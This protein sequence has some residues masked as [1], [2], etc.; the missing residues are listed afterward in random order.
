MNQEIGNLEQYVAKQQGQER[1]AIAGMP[2]NPNN[3]V[4]F[5]NT[6]PG[7]SFGQGST[8]PGSAVGQGS[9]FTPPPQPPGPPPQ[10]QPPG[11]GDPGG[12]GYRGPNLPGNRYK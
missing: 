1:S 11:S 8:T 6:G 3:D 2:L 7:L 10:K 12:G 4:A 5:G 9:P